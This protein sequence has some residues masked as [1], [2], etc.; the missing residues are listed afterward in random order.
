M[1]VPIFSVY[2]RAILSYL[3]P[4]TLR[5]VG[6]AKRQLLDTVKDENHQFSQ[7]PS[8]FHLVQVGSFNDS[9]GTIEAFDPPVLIMK[10]DEAMATTH[11]I[12][13]NP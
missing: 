8:D 4:F 3:P 2:D 13:G 10:C 7:H 5:T 11:H 1:L 9:S 6:E 12:K